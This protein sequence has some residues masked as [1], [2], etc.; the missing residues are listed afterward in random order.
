MKNKNKIISIVLVAFV[1]IALNFGSNSYASSLSMAPST[2]LI[3]GASTT[4]T[5]SGADVTGRFNISSS[6]SG[7]VSLSSGSVW[8]ENNSA[9][10]TATSKAAG[11]ATITLTPTDVSNGAG[12]DITSSIGSKSVIITVKAAAITPTPTPTQTPTQTTTTNG[13]ANLNRLVPNYEGLA[14]NFNSAITKYSL[15]VP[16]TATSLGLSIGVEAAGAKYWISGDENLKMGDNTVSITVTATNGTKKVYTII[17]TKA[18][19]VAKANAYL[20]SIVIDGKT[21]TPV[22]TAENLEYDIG[23][24]KSDVAKL[25]VLAFAQADNSKIEITGNDALVD[26]INTIK[27]KVI[28]IDGTTTKEY[29][30]KVNKEAGAIAAVTTNN[31]VDIYPEANN[32]QG[33]NPSGFRSFLNEVGMVLRANWLVLSLLL[34]CIFE[35]AQVLYCYMK[36][37][38]K[39]T[40]KKIKVEE[41]NDTTLSRRRNT[42]FVDNNDND[43]SLKTNFKNEEAIDDISDELVEDNKD[44][45]D[46]TK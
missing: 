36:F 25:T 40:A 22:F 17:V 21:L 37:V 41:N 46:N 20:S 19:D 35:F 31:E 45:E 3:I 10:I 32:L 14:P 33:D 11:S 1:F 16:S 26:G 15:T 43:S 24:V 44:M 4:I 34:V 27:I 2:T 42:E 39:S 30:I 38:R 28:A 29:T 7:I 9:T 6:N 23:T 5:I 18:A 13:N 8:I 12:T